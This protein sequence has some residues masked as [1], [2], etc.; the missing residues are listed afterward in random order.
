VVKGAK[1]R[2]VAFSAQK[3]YNW[4]AQRGIAELLADETRRQIKRYLYV[5]H[6]VGALKREGGNYV[7]TS[8]SPLW[9]HAIHGLA[10]VYIANILSVPEFPPGEGG[11]GKEEATKSS[12]RVGEEG[13]AGRRQVDFEGLPPVGGGVRRGEAAGQISSSEDCGRSREGTGRKNPA[14]A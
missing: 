1:G 12:N 6:R 4:C 3:I 10:R 5:L 2:V 13:R 8:D 11:R 9:E 14:V 7:L